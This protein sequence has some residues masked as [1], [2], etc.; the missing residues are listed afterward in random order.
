MEQLAS[1][2]GWPSIIKTLTIRAPN[3]PFLANLLLD[4]DRSDPLE[5]PWPDIVLCAE[6]RTSV[7]ARSIQRRSRGNVK[8]ICLGRPAG[9][10]A[11]FDLILTTAQ[12]RLPKAPNVFELALPLA[13][14]SSQSVA[15][16]EPKD[17]AEAESFARPVTAVFVGGTSLPELLDGEAAAALARHLADHARKSGGTLLVTT[18][19]RTDPE[20]GLA[21]ARALPAPHVVHQWHAGESNPYRRL[22]ALADEIIVTSDS[23]SM[24]ADALA[25]EKTVLVYRLPQSWTPRHRLIEWLFQRV[26]SEP[27]CPFWLRPAK[28]LFDSGLIEARAD[29]TRLFDRLAQ[30][31]RLGW[32]GET[33]TKA[34]Y[35]SGER[36]IKL[37]VA[38]ILELWPRKAPDSAPL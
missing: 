11:G 8:V 32:F 21:L 29:R 13:A 27:R 3:I 18:S 20:V 35:L 16:A 17:I 5:P 1:M 24:V 14:G 7:I 31:G 25:T 2:L 33:G 10:T 36:D 30:E 26:A 23:V 6:A 15:A 37:I 28:W 12:Y 9:S 38:R 22:L 34:R 19:P 4:R